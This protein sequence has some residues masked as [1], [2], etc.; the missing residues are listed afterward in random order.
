MNYKI[1][2]LKFMLAGFFIFLEKKSVFSSDPNWKMHLHMFVLFLKK[3]LDKY[4][5][6]QKK[7][8]LLLLNSFFPSGIDASSF[9][10]ES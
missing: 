7:M 6:V 5:F 2:V 10:Y 4:N 3:I 8:Y 9:M 1:D